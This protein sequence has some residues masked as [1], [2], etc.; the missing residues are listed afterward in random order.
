MF[1][2]GKEADKEELADAYFNGNLE[3]VKK[4]VEAKGPGKWAKWLRAAK[5]GNFTE[6]D[7]L[8]K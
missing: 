6:A 8:L 1:T 2:E 4:A 5:L 3:G 7:N